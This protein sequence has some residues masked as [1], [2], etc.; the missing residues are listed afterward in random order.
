MVK[1]PTQVSIMKYFEGADTQ[2]KALIERWKR[3]EKPYG[4]IVAVGG[5]GLA[6][7]GVV[8]IAPAVFAALTPVVTAIISVLAVGFT[9]MISPAIYS[10]FR[11]ITRSFYK[12]VI[13]WKPFDEVDDSRDKMWEGHALY[14]AKKANI[15]KLRNEFEEMSNQ[16]QK[17]AEDAKAEISLQTKKASAYKAQMEDLIAKKGE[18]IKETDE[19]VEI[20]QKFINAASAGTRNSTTMDK[21]IE[22]TQKY[23]SRSNILATLDRKLAIGATL[24]ENK[25]YDFEESIMLMKKEYEMSGAM[26][27]ATDTLIQVLGPNGENWKLSYAIDFINDQ[28][29]ENLAVSAQ[30]LEDL[31]RNTSAFNFDSDEAYDTLLKISNKIDAGQVVIPDS[32]RISNFNHKL[33]Q[34]EKV[35]AGPLGNIF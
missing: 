27:G 2:G 12:A 20:Q 9:I 15:K 6:G 22:W 4:A 33:T 34:A 13:R 26:R 19:F 24:M 1:A 7:W 21:N 30:N 31:D 18:A 23:A 8:S 5:I 16:T 10:A 35:S 14:L 32:N 25:I 29:S 28:I 11:K 17:A 3:N